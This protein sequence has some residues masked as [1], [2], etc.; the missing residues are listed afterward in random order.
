MVWKKYFLSKKK[1]LYSNINFLLLQFLT[2]FKITI[3][4]NPNIYAVIFFERIQL[5]YYYIII[6]L[7]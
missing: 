1:S 3:P 5:F 6:L 7:F 2:N 4:K